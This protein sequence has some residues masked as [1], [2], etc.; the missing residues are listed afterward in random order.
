MISTTISNLQAT[1]IYERLIYN[2]QGI[3]SGEMNLPLMS[4]NRESIGGRTGLDNITGFSSS[5]GNTTMSYKPGTV[6]SGLDSWS[7]KI[8]DIE[9]YVPTGNGMHYTIDNYLQS[10]QEKYTKN[11]MNPEHY[12]NAMRLVNK[13]NEL[14][15]LIDYHGIITSGYRSPQRQR[16]IYAAKG[17]KPAM[18]SKHIT[19]HAM[20]ISDPKGELKQKFLNRKVLEKMKELDLYLENFDMTKTWVHIQDEAPGFC[21]RQIWSAD[22]LLDKHRL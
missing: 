8:E 14:G 22:N 18:G 6:S 11:T 15:E 9:P 1:L 2:S 21:G 20:D 3:N 13:V 16:E 17:E 7:G 4:V 5:V 19:G 10:G 12:N